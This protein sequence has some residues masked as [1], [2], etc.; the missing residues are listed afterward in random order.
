MGSHVE[1]G[2]LPD[3]QLMYQKYAALSPDAELFLLPV[4]LQVPVLNRLGIMC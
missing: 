4:C 3:Y 2:C 1:L